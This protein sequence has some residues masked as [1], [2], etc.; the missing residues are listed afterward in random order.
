MHKIHLYMYRHL[1]CAQVVG[2]YSFPVFP[3]EKSTLHLVS[4]C[5]SY[6]QKRR[7]RHASALVFFYLL[8]LNISEAHAP[9]PSP[10]FPPYQQDTHMLSIYKNLYR[11]TTRWLSWFL[12][13]KAVNLFKNLLKIW[14]VGGKNFN[15]FRWLE[16][17]LLRFYPHEDN[18]YLYIFNFGSIFIV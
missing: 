11:C 15:S 5:T 17:L 2:W 12:S 14:G 7:F 18:G 4:W 6:M 9:S 3:P 16:F 10:L 8:Q 1:P 13:C